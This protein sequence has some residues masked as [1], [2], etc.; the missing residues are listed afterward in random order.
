MVNF[1]HRTSTFQ[2]YE[3]AIFEE[4]QNLDLIHGEMID[5]GHKRTQSDIRSMITIL[6]HF[7][8]FENTF[9]EKAKLL[10][11]RG[12]GTT[13]KELVLHTQ[14]FVDEM[15]ERGLLVRP[16]LES[17]GAY[18][19]QNRT[20]QYEL[21]KRCEQY[22]FYDQ[23]I[24]DDISAAMRNFT[25]ILNLTQTSIKRG[26]YELSPLGEQVVKREKTIY[27]RVKCD[28]GES[29]RKV[30][31]TNAIGAFSI[32]L[33]CIA[34]GLCVK[35][36]PYGALEIDCEKTPQLKFNPEL[37][38]KSKGTPNKP[39]ICDFRKIT[40]EELNL[41]MWMKQVFKLMSITSEITG[42]GEFPDL[43]TL[44]E[45]AFIEVKKNRITEKRK[46]QVKEQILRYSQSN[47]I[48][49]TLKQLEYFTDYSWKKLE[50]LIL[51]SPE[52]GKEI[53]LIE[54]LR[55]ERSETE[56]GYI[57]INKLFSTCKEIFRD[58]STELSIKEMI[59]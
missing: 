59:N 24:G 44:E 49:K 4:K 52:E 23:R 21:V 20:I 10:M 43:V 26:K 16:F 5:L 12:S 9:K 45:P 17:V 28:Q 46:E 50:L 40:A 42:I 55:D 2:V 27:N 35:V 32:N 54:E 31:P 37:C 3:L 53:D 56:I 19:N 13:S 25:S 29:C 48:E 41:Q 39:R 51:A 33:N 34:C 8:L 36:C 47:V 1:F 7:G 6:N 11:E 18:P 57:S 30:C 38:E 14:E 22:G 15:M 58:K